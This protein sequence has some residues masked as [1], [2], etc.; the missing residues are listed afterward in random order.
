MKEFVQKKRR[1]LSLV[2]TPATVDGSFDATLHILN[3]SFQGWVQGVGPNGH[4]HDFQAL[5]TEE[6]LQVN[7]ATVRE[8]NCHRYWPPEVLESF[9]LAE[10]ITRASQEDDQLV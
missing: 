4:W 6:F 9:R 7:L 10:V 5:T 1:P 2:N 8:S 3:R